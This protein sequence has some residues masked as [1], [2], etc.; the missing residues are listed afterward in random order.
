MSL[1]ELLPISISALLMLAITGC[2]LASVAYDSKAEQHARSTAAETI[3]AHN[4][5]LDDRYE[6]DDFLLS[7]KGLALRQRA[8]RLSRAAWLLALV[9]VIW[10]TVLGFY[11]RAL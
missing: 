3:I 7:D 2:A 4:Y 5:E 1:R 9:A 6:P 10:G 8:Q 11:G